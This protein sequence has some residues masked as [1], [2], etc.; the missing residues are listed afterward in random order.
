MTGKCWGGERGAGS[1]KDFEAG[2]ELGSLL[3][4]VALYVDTLYVE[5]IGADGI[6]LLN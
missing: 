2:F 3:S 4:A 1:A 5:A 6:L